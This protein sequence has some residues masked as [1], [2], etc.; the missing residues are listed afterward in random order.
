[1][2]TKYT[3]KVLVATDLPCTNLK[4]FFDALFAGYV[5]RFSLTDGIIRYSD[6]KLLWDNFKTQI[7]IE[8]LPDFNSDGIYEICEE[9]EVIVNWYDE[10]PPQG[11]LCKVSGVTDSL[12]V[13]IT[14][15]DGANFRDTNHNT[16][17]NP[18][19][20]TLKEILPFIYNKPENK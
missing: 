2:T 4:E 16:W 18:V 14:Q 11:I 7:K 3:K 19:P 8:S 12:Y 6:N 10:I 20:V 13:K 15:Y 5:I 9:K 1:M 17:F